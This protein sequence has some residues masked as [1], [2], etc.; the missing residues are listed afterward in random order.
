MNRGTHTTQSTTGSKV[1]CFQLTGAYA[2]QATD[3]LKKPVKLGALS[4]AKVISALLDGPCSV[5]ELMGQSGLSSNTVHEYMRAL[6][7][8]GVVHIGAWEKD[9]TG[10]ESLRIFK[11][12]AGKDV[13][14]TRKSKAQIARE[15]RMRKKAA[16]Q[17]AEQSR[18][19]DGQN[20]SFFWPM[21]AEGHPIL[22]VRGPHRANPAGP[23]VV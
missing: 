20:A 14:R 4:M 13:P 9:A 21:G 2:M 3:N 10:R 16:L 22:K 19:C 11:F 7:K 18:L 1:R 12:G 6:R 17:L 8:E 15:C 23:G 5:P